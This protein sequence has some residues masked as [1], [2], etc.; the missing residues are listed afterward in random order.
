MSIGH[1]IEARDLDLE[2]ESSS[3]QYWSNCREILE[4]AKKFKDYTY[5]AL[6]LR[7]C[8][9]R[10]C[11][12]YLVLFTHNTRELSRNE[13]KLYRPKTI[14]QKVLEEEPFFEKKV[15][16]TN[17]VFAS[18]NLR[19]RI[20]KP[21]FR[22][23]VKSHGKLGRCLHLQTVPLTVANKKSYVEFVIKEHTE[24]RTYF[25][26]CRGGIVTFRSHAQPVWDKFVK[27]EITKEA[28]E[29]MVQ[30]GTLPAHMYNPE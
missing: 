4:K 26:L 23:L 9:E 20:V 18:H 25:D 14:L 1:L 11:F 13:R 5:A 24:L 8:I 19:E 27:G 3:E 29:R 10:L 17:A 28:M 6:E 21:D 30:L 2:Y 12:D 16:F 7:M 22:K 15:D